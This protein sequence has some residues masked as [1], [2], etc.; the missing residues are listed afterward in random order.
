MVHELYLN[1][2]VFIK[3]LDLS[4]IPTHHAPQPTP[5]IGRTM[6]AYTVPV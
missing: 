2:A 6:L 5:G 3:Y 1:Q 4:P